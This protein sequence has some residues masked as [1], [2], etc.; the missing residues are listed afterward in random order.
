MSE[1]VG[2]GTA[3]LLVAHGS[4]REASNDEVR[5][6]A[7]KLAALAGER[8]SQVDAA[9]LELAE[10]SIPDGIARCCERGAQRV[11]V[12]PYFL[13]AGR[14]VVT[15]IPSDVDQ[16]R[17]RCPEVAVELCGYLGGSEAMPELLLELAAK[18]G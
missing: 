4:R 1:H 6:V 13:S 11:L 3:L 2:S 12:L 17:T 16:G 7:Q 9:F 8:F 15:D 10:P 5:A 18:A 14:H